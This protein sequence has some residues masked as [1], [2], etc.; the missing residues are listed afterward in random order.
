[1]PGLL[2]DLKFKNKF[3]CTLISFRVQNFAENRKKKV[4]IKIKKLRRNW[5]APIPFLVSPHFF[6]FLSQFLLLFSTHLL[7]NSFCFFRRLL[8]QFLHIPFPIYSINSNSSIDSIPFTS[9]F[10]LNL[11]HKFFPLFFLS[12]FFGF[13]HTFSYSLFH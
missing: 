3:C 10:M 11:F 7:L 12:F 1:M 13:F 5:S 4:S 9:Q 8:P 2:L 6:L